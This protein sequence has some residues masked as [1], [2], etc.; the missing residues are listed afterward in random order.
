MVEKPRETDLIVA[1]DLNVDLGKAGSRGRD[2]EITVAVV[3]AGLEDLP[4][5]FFLRRRAWCRDRRMWE[6]RRQ[7]MVVR[8]RTEYILGYDCRIFQNVAVQY[9]RHNSDHF[10]GHGK[11]A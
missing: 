6:T 7:G 5:Y 10:H 4:G 1:G 9:P 8:S 2:E 11:P 3:M